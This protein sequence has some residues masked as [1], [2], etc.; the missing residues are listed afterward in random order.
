MTDER[1]AILGSGDATL[2]FSDARADGHGGVQMTVA[3]AIGTLRAPID[4]WLHAWAPDL[5]DFFDGLAKDWRGWIGGREWLTDG[6]QL[7]CS[8]DG[9]GHVTIDVVV[10]AIAPPLLGTWTV[11]TT[12]EVEPGS[13]GGTAGQFRRLLDPR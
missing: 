11:H 8:H 10:G 12:V 9:V 2:T 5:A 3:L 1:I 6:L 13:L 4:V 7:T